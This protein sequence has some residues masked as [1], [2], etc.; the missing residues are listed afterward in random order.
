MAANPVGRRCK[1]LAPADIFSCFLT[2]IQATQSWEWFW[3]WPLHIAVLSLQPGN[4]AE[5]KKPKCSSLQRTA[6]QQARPLHRTTKWGAKGECLGTVTASRTTLNYR[7]IHDKQTL[8]ILCLT[9][10]LTTSPP[11]FQ[12]IA[13]GALCGLSLQWKN[14][15]FSQLIKTTQA[16]DHQST[17]CRLI[18]A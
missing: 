2:N 8:H 13:V 1:P 17:H 10:L 14:M 6:W 15:D 4:R 11:A 12:E 5:R 9:R 18:T 7:K 16:K 3:S